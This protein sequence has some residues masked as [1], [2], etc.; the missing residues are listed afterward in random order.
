MSGVTHGALDGS[1]PG[2]TVDILVEDL[3]VAVSKDHV[4]V[5]VDGGGVGLVR[6]VLRPE[7]AKSLVLLA[8]KGLCE[9]E[10]HIY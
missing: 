7:L 8:A 2:D 1:D 6:L 10:R 5:V 9:Q 3:G 4:F